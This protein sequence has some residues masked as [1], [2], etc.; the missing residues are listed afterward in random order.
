MAVTV[1]RLEDLQGA[2]ING[3]LPDRAVTVVQVEWHGTQAL[4]LTYRNDGGRVDQQLLYRADEAAA[5]EVED[6]GRAWSFDADGALF[7]LASEAL[8]IRLA[9]LLDPH[10]A[11]HPSNLDPLVRAGQ[12]ER[13]SFEVEAPSSGR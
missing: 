8:R 11:V 3:V 12:A 6:V 13:R 1:A 10:L 9:H 2:H 7:R 4:T 5:L